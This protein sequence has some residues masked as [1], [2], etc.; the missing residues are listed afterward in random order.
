L[1]QAELHYRNALA[2]L[3]DEESAASG[4]AAILCQR[5]DVGEAEARLAFALKCRPRSFGLWFN[6]G[7]VKEL[8]HRRID[9]RACFE[10]AAQLDATQPGIVAKARQYGFAISS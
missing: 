9:A 3:P 2:K 10:R 1:K 5:G 8:Q 6:L 4:L 7:L